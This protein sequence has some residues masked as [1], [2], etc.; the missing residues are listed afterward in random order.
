MRASPL[1]PRMMSR[2]AETALSPTIPPSSEFQKI[3]LLLKEAPRLVG[4]VL[5]NAD[6]GDELLTENWVRQ[7]KS[8]E[9]ARPARHARFA[10]TNRGSFERSFRASNCNGTLL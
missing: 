3:G 2:W 8:L 7:L 6:V 4:V 10:D 1:P 5:S 9:V